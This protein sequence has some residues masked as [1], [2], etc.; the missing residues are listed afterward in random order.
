MCRELL[1]WLE[2]DVIPLP[3]IG[4]RANAGTGELRGLGDGLMV[5]VREH[6]YE[7]LMQ[8]YAAMLKIYGLSW[9][10]R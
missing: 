5:K 4:M 3:E 7:K 1:Q 2:L 9:S 10:I 8:T 6:L